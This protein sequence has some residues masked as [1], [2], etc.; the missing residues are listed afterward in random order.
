MI[1]AELIIRGVILLLFVLAVIVGVWIVLLI[2]SLHR[3]Y[4]DNGEDVK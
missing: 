3:F 1:D 2:R 4:D